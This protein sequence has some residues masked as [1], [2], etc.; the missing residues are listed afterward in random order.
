ME[1]NEDI[2]NLL[3]EARK[4]KNLI[5][6]IVCNIVEE[7]TK[8][9][10]ELKQQLAELKEQNNRLKSELAELK[11]NAIVPKFKINHIVWYIGNDKVQKGTIEEI[12]YYKTTGISYYLPNLQRET[13]WIYESELFATQS[14]AE[15][16]LKKLE[17]VWA[18]E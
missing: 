5:V 18:I 15:E 6:D 1:Q 12:R 10:K 9:I 13:F 2:K 11:Q 8:E 17:E 14:E 7:N 3:D 4:L 16:A